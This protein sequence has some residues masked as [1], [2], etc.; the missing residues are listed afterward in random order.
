[1]RSLNGKDLLFQLP[2]LQHM[3]TSL[4]SCKPTGAAARDEVIQVSIYL[5]CQLKNTKMGM[6]EIIQHQGKRPMP[7]CS[8][9]FE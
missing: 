5:P 7:Y 3:L 9:D 4:G 1:M 8:C 2:V 6:C